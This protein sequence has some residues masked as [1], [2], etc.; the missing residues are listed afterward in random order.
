MDFES[1][2]HDLHLCITGREEPSAPAAPSQLET[3]SPD[4]LAGPYGP[5]GSA[6][7]L[8]APGP[9]LSASVA[10]A[11]GVEKHQWRLLG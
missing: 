9:F 10:D 6:H 1:N 2:R 3:L 7:S 8:A 4:N 11:G 5:G